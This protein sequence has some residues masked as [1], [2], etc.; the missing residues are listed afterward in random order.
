MMINMFLTLS[1]LTLFTFCNR[2]KSINAII[3]MA[4]VPVHLPAIVSPAH[5]GEC[6]HDK[7]GVLNLLMG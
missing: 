2:E 7:M 1:H 5:V 4:V 3:A 6:H